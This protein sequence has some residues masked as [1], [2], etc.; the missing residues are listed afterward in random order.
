MTGRYMRIARWLTEATH[1][2]SVYVILIAFPLQRL[3]ITLYV[4][5]PSC[6]VLSLVHIFAQRGVPGV[7]I[8]VFLIN[9]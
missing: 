5:C 4:N 8:H 1:T 3:N 7:V 6:I 9:V 2:H